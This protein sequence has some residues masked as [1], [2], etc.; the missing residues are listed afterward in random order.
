MATKIASRKGLKFSETC[1]KIAYMNSEKL[2]L[3]LIAIFSGLLVA[4]VIFF[5]YQSTKTISPNKITTFNVAKP[6]PT[7]KPA[8]FLTIDTPTDESVT[9]NPTVTI[10]GKTTPDATIIIDTATTDQVVTPSATGSYSITLDLSQGENLINI[11]AVAAD[12]NEVN[13]KL[14]LTYSTEAF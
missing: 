14:T 1:A 4:F 5:I 2:V 8:V 6:T 13:K 9:A 10:N 12:G 11:T 3:S 7:P